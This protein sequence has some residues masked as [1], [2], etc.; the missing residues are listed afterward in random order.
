MIKRLIFDV[1]GTLIRGVTFTNSIERTLK[2]FNIY[3]EENVRSFIEATR[4]YENSHDN[5]N[6]ADYTAHVEKLIKTKV[7]DNF[8]AT[9][10]L[11][12]I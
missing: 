11:S 2:R 4:T 5:Y 6:K 1:D 12:L 7:P 8:L 10:L 9:S 3:S